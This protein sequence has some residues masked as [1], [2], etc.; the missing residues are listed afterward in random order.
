MVT[1]VTTRP[2]PSDFYSA[3]TR[4]RSSVHGLEVRPSLPVIRVLR[5]ANM[6]LVGQCSTAVVLLRRY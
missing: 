3:R 2:P 6:I 5:D 1:I 4:A